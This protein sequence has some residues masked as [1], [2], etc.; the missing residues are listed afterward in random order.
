MTEPSEPSNADLDERLTK[1]EEKADESGSGGYPK[2]PPGTALAPMFGRKAQT[3]CAA[4]GLAV[5]LLSAAAYVRLLWPADT[6]QGDATVDGAWTAAALTS[7]ATFAAGAVLLSTG[8]GL[9]MAEA[10][11][12]VAAPEAPEAPGG[13]Q[14][15]AAGA[16]TITEVI[17]AVSSL[18]DKLTPARLL[19]AVGLVLLLANAWV[20]KG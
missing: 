5:G 15:S 20:A 7:A 13:P 14:R 11:R 17:E 3:R 8:V 1:L 16:S 2:P 9:L 18:A 10:M 4:A 6:V 12:L 19:V